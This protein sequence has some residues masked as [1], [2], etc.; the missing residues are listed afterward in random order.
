MNRESTGPILATIRKVALVFDDRT[1]PETTGFYCRRALEKLAE[2]TFFHPS[3]L[4]DVPR[5]AFDLY[6]NIDDGMRYLWPADLRPSAW[7]A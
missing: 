5:G 4:A 3:Q 6:L 2:V 1:R 7:W